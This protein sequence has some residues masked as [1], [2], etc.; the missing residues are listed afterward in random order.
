MGDHSIIELLLAEAPV[1]LGR[2]AGH[3]ACPL[4]LAPGEDLF[5]S[6]QL[7]LLRDVF[8]IEFF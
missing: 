3:P 2:P 7:F 1:S 8:A 5:P 4:F 6:S